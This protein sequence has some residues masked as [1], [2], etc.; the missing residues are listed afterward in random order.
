VSVSEHYDITRRRRRPEQQPGPA[1][2]GPPRPLSAVDSATFA[3]RILSASPPE[4]VVLATRANCACFSQGM[5]DALEEYCP[6]VAAAVGLGCNFGSTDRAQL[7]LWAVD[8][9]GLQ[10]DFGPFFL[11]EE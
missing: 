7:E 8:C 4:E 2:G 5:L 9:P 11:G 10:G 6:E 3:E 1:P